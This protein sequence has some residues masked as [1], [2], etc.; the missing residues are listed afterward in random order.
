MAWWGVWDR[1]PVTCEIW[2]ENLLGIMAQ[3]RY[4]FSHTFYVWTYEKGLADN[5]CS[6]F[7]LRNIYFHIIECVMFL[8]SSEVTTLHGMSCLYSSQGKHTH[9]FRSA[10]YFVYMHH[11][12]VA[13]YVEEHVID[14]LQ[15]KC[16]LCFYK[17]LSNLHV[18]TKK[19]QGCFVESRVR[20]FCWNFGFICILLHFSPSWP[21]TLKDRLHLGIARSRLEI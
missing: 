4:E 14:V 6:N 5:W 2:L 10:L 7:Y 3:S 1:K 9:K 11:L 13:E 18:Q 19:L 8:W 15:G 12:N 20:M 16:H 21:K 17:V